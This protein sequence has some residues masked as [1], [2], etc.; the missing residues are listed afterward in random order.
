MAEFNNVYASLANFLQALIIDIP[1]DATFVD[2]DQYVSLDTLPFQNIV[3]MRGFTVD[4]GNTT[5]E[6]KVMFCIATVDDDSMFDHRDIL[7][8]LF[9]LC[10]PTKHVP[11]VDA[12]TG[13]VL[14]QFTVAA[15]TAILPVHRST[16]RTFQMMMV[17]LLAD[18]KP[19]L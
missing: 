10:Q 5:M 8:R 12:T 13:E 11:Y 7:D 6:V 15:G 17:N 18:R 19:K 2:F 14:G 16:A 4:S 3:G 9:T 1:Y